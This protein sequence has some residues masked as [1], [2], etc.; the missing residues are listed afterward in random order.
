MQL[1]R[2]KFNQILDCVLAFLQ[3][4]DSKHIFREFD[5]AKLLHLFVEREQLKDDKE[6]LKKI[7]EIVRAV[8]LSQT[9][10]QPSSE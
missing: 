2:Y 3:M 4:K 10:L 1:S 5:M 6:V 9:V 8:F 7:E